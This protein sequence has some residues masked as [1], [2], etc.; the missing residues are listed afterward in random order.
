MTE[1]QIEQLLLRLTQLENLVVEQ[2]AR[3]KEL[4]EQ[5]A[6]NSHNSS[7]PPSSDGL[8]KGSPKPRSLRGKSDKKSGGQKGHKGHTL[9]QSDTPDNVIKHK[10]LD[11]QH[12]HESL[13]RAELMHTIK[14]QVF[15][16]PQPQLEVT[17]HQAEVKI[18][19]YCQSKNTAQ[20]PDNVRAPV[21]Y[22]ENVKAM[23]V[24]LSQSQLLPQNRLKTLF[25]DLFGLPIAASTI[26][27]ACKAIYQNLLGFESDVL[28]KIQSSELTHLDETGLRVLSKT[29]WLHVASNQSATYYHVSEKRKS[30]L[31]GLTG[32]IVHDHWKPYFQIEN[33][34]HALCNAHHLRELNARIDNE[35]RWAHQMQRWMH[36]ALDMKYHYGE[37]GIPEKIQTRLLTIYDDIV[38]RGIKYH[39][40]LPELPRKSSR[41]GRAAKRKG[42]NLVLRFMN[43]RDASTRFIT[44]WDIPFTNNLAEQDLRMMKVQQKI[45]GCFRSWEGARV[46]ARIRTLTSTA[47]KQSWDIFQ[48]IKQ[49]I[50]APLCPNL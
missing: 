3:I 43:F 35:E 41:R 12:C 21:Q 29:H 7:K 1:K 36:V 20:F 33:V 44:T 25:M 4:E 11:C 34:S 49:A 40:S 37:D 19:L 2:A 23:A 39:E 47:R 14:R 18:C 8:K 16:I 32:V 26:E 38:L 50:A 31:P 6:K 17:E 30:L 42:H 28:R 27:N 9:K 48:T 15:E 24:Y 45:S 5:L 10:L 13:A 46:F 22:G